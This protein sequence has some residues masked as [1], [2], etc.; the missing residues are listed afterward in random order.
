MRIG[1]G[2]D[3]EE[4]RAIKKEENERADAA[5]TEM[6]TVDKELEEYSNAEESELNFV[7]HTKAILRK[8]VLV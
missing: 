8:K 7:D 4:A 5:N 2:D 1:H 6:I 3:V